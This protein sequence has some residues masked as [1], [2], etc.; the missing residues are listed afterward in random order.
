ML[1]ASTRTRALWLVLRKLLGMN[2][3]I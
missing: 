3:S 1:I 2:G